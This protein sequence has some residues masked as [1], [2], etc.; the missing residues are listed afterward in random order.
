MTIYK[1]TLNGTIKESYNVLSD[2]MYFEIIDEKDNVKYFH[3]VPTK[4]A[5]Q[6]YLHGCVIDEEKYKKVVRDYENQ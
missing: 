3:I 4:Y 6:D 2:G 5:G 1:M